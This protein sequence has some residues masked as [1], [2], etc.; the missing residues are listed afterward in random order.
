MPTCRK[1]DNVVVEEGSLCI[2]CEPEEIGEC[3]TCGK[4]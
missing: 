1:C 4:K 3:L 2:R